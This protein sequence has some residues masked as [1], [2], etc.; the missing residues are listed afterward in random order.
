[1][2]TATTTSYTNAT[3]LQHALG[4][5]ATDTNPAIESVTYDR[6]QWL[7]QQPGN[8]AFLIGDPATGP[9]LRRARPGRR[10]R[11]QGRRRQAGLL[12]QPEP[13]GQRQGGHDHRARARHPQRRRITLLA[14]ASQTKYGNAWL[15]LVGQY[16]GN[17]VRPRPSTAST[18]SGDGQATKVGERQRRRRHGRQQHQGRRR[19]RR[20][21]LRLLER[22]DARERR[23][24]AS[25]SSTTRTNTAGGQPAK[26]VSWVDLTD[27]ATPTSTKADVTTAIGT[28]G[29]ANLTQLDQFA[30]WKDEVN[31]QAGRPGVDD[32]RPRQRA[33]RSSPTPTSARRRL[34]DQPGHLPRAG[35]P[36]QERARTPNAVILFGGTWCPNTRPVLA[37]RSTS[38]RR[39]TTSR[40]S[41]STPSS[42]AAWPAAARP[43]RQPA[44]DAQ[45]RQQR[46]DDGERQPQLPLRRPREPVPHEHQDA[47]RP[48]DDQPRHLLPGRRHHRHR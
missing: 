23:W 24:T 16:L 12:V 37:G 17:G 20:R 7:L 11:R 42:T 4:L 28:V 26:I 3:Y 25:S 22:R 41:T 44:P 47:V 43:A 9:D 34:A 45:H 31:A 48:R 1:M 40:S 36:A 32:R 33:S 27:K 18:A 46:H 8:F 21:A 2:R 10:G 14:A 19:Q 15:N 38:T 6:F 29:A 35:R 13:L 5:P 39:R 30:W